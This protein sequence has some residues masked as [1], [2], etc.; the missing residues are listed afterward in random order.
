MQKG[1][2][3]VAE[4]HLAGLDHGFLLMGREEI[5]KSNNNIIDVSS[6]IVQILSFYQLVLCNCNASILA[7]LHQKY[8]LH[9]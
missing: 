1:Q 4:A 9:I 5:L 7:Q 3:N 2:A 6:S 8:Q